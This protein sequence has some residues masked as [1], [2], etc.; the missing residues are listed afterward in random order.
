MNSYAFEQCIFF[1]VWSSCALRDLVTL[2]ASLSKNE[3]G[4]GENGPMKPCRKKVL[5]N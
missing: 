1:C 3:R 4:K 5:V 2:T